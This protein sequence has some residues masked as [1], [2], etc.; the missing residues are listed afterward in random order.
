M[1]TFMIS[2]FVTE[3][4]PDDQPWPPDGDDLWCVV[5]RSHGFTRWRR[6]SLQQK[7]SPIVALGGG[8][9]NQAAPQSKTRN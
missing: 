3:D 1:S 2:Y 5:A 9:A 8:L 6:I 4:Y 7:Q